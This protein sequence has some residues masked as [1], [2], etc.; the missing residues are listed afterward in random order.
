MKIANNTFIVTGGASGLGKASAVALHCA[1]AN[2]VLADRNVDQGSLLADELGAGVAFKHTDVADESDARVCVNFALERFG[3]LQGLV[4]CA[5][6]VAASKTYGK[7]GVHDLAQFSRTVQ[8]NL[9]GSFNMARLTAEAMAGNSPDADGSRGIIINTA[10]IAAYEGQVGQVAYAASKG[11][12]VAMTLPMARDLAPLGI[13]VMTIAP[14]LFGTPMLSELPEEAQ[15]S[16]GQSV[17]YPSRLGDPAEYAQLVCSI[18]ENNMLN[19]ETI[20]LDGA[21]RMAPH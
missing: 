3:S 4:N 13:R 7:R 17:P 5:G 10:S 2:V 20:R 1:G 18:V 11:G 16:L 6:I 9:V 8:V 19:G 12:V 14:G 15:R 21:L